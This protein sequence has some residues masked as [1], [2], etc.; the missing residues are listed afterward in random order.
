[1]ISALVAWS[2]LQDPSSSGL[3]VS[4]L[5]AETLRGVALSLLVVVTLIGLSWLARHLTGV[6]SASAAREPQ[7]RPASGTHTASRP[8]HPPLE[9]LPDATD[10]RRRASGTDSPSSAS[11]EFR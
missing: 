6:P 4:V 9:Q 8:D 11:P 5:P 2:R 3:P 1:M 7:P 10:Q